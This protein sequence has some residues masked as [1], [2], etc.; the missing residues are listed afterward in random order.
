MVGVEGGAFSRYVDW[1]I[2][3]RRTVL[4]LVLATSVFWAARLPALRVEV[5]PDANLPQDHPYIEALHTL[6]DRFGEKNLVVIGLFPTDGNVYTPA[7]LAKLVAITQRIRDQPGL[8]RATF[9]GIA[10]PRAKAIETVG[11][12]LLIRPVLEGSVTAPGVA[13]ETRRRLAANDFYKG[14]V[15][16]DDGSAAAIIANFRLNPEL[17]GLPQIQ[18]R[19]TS[20]LEE[21]DDGTFAFHFGGIVTVTAGIATVT[22]QTILLFPFALLVVGLIHLEAFR[23]FQGMILP[24]I[25]AVLAVVWSLG[26]MGLRGVP[27]DPFNTTTPVLILA[28]AAGHAVQ[29]LKRYYEEYD[30]CGDS[31]A[32][33]RV[34]LLRVGPVMIAAGTIAAL[35]FF[36][37]S[38]FATAT[39]RNFGLMTGFGILSAL[40]LELTLIPALRLLLP[41][42]RAIELRRE[43]RSGRAIERALGQLARLVTARPAAIVAACALACIVAAGS[44]TN[45]RVD[46]SFKRQFAATHQI[47]VSDDALNAAFAGT[48]TLVFLV[49][50]E[51]DGALTDPTV[52]RAIADLQRFVASDPA[53][54][55]TFSVVDL[56][57]EM[58]RA[59]QEGDAAVDALPDSSDLVSQYLLLYSMSGGPED[60]DS[61][62]DAERRSAAVRVFLDDD[63]TIYGEELLARVRRQVAAT[64]PPGYV[65]RYSGTVASSAALTEV[66]V[67]GKILNMLQIAAIIMVVSGLVLRSALAG[68]LV[69]TPLAMAVL[70]NFGVMGATGIPL[71]VM[72][73]PIAAMAVGIGS[74]YAIYFLFRFREELATSAT[75]AL[76]LASALRTSG[77]AILYVSSAIAGGYLVLCTSGSVFH[78]ELGLMVALAMI[79]SSLAAIT[80]LPSLLLLAEPAFL[81]DSRTRTPT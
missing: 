49:E 19:L 63:S 41:A 46:T 17:P 40:V 50:G 4:V 33:V 74:D 62:I 70:I 9:L 45:L 64:F 61:H 56:L 34:T 73:A 25:T 77:K 26:L 13:E 31:V 15:V 81:F 66:M 44:A 30:R 24:L 37:L 3:W 79:V 12:A 57:R 5:D 80:L 76:A 53:V 75:R 42:P 68:L 32:A 23:T 65:V 28:V 6:E 27:L 51:H 48:S 21:E 60:L 29:I 71:D 39:I 7:F 78:L 35:S 43:A 52:L 54:G 1:L 14:I 20:I 69:T 11:D 58:H 36:S 47:R 38:V 8:V 18:N 72:T 55:K 10:S 16:S 22:E 2:V 59:L 67:R